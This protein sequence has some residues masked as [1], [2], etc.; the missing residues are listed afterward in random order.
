MA[1][2]LRAEGEAEAKAITSAADR[3]RDAILARAEA[4]ADRIRGRGEAEATRTLNE[5]HSRDPKFHLADT[6]RFL[7]SLHAHHVSEVSDD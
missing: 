2:T 5:A 3:E 7:Q 4:E 6:A 1:A